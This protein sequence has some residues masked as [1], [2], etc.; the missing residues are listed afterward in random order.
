[1]HEGTIVV[2]DNSFYTIH[3]GPRWD[4]VAHGHEL[5]D[6]ARHSIPH[7]NDGG[8]NFKDVGD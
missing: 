3:G 6:E 7:N 5:G 1:M 4:L 2:I 8:R